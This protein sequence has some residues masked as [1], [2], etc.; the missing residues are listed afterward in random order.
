MKRSKRTF[1]VWE[2]LHAGL[3]KVVKTAADQKIIKRKKILAWVFQAMG[4]GL[5]L[6]PGLSTTSAALPYL[7][8]GSC[9]MGIGVILWIHNLRQRSKD[10]GL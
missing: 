10:S 3:D 2:Y 4:L 9:L 6:G 5:V 7:I 1:F 8:G